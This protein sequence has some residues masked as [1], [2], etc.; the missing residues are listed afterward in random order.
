MKAQFGSE[1]TAL[2]RQEGLDEASLEDASGKQELAALIHALKIWRCNLEGA[3][4]TV[5]VDHN[6]LVHLL[7]KVLNRWQVR[8]LD[9]L[10]TY[11]GLKIVHIPGK[12]NIAD[13]LSR[14][15]HKIAQVAAM[16]RATLAEQP[17]IKSAVLEAMQTWRAGVKQQP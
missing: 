16:P 15:D 14:I 10:A 13:G 12:D 5:Y 4:F 8:I 3:D 2:H 7:Q 1:G 11:P 17:A 6:P 9:T